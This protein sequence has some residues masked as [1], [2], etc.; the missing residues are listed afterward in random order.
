MQILTILSKFPTFTAIALSLLLCSSGLL[1]Q[2]PDESASP[3]VEELE[4]NLESE[5]EQLESVLQ[6]REVMLAEQADIRD[7]LAEQERQMKEKMD[8]LRELCEQHNAVNKND[9]LDC[10][11]EIGGS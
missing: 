1:A 2:S 3:V 11:K 4:K 7:Q 10:D 5:Q 9:P 8:A 6:E